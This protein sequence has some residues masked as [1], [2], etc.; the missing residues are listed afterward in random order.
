M[1]DYY[2]LRTFSFFLFGADHAARSSVAQTPDAV[3]DEPS[4][5]ALRDVPSESVEIL[6]FH[7]GDADDLGA[8]GRKLNRLVSNISCNFR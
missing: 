6:A 7:F 4:R 8:K 5:S 2:V 1:G 3:V